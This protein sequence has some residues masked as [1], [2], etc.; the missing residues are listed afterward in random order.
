[1]FC[2]RIHR[3]VT[4]LDAVVNPD[5]VLC[6]RIRERALSCSHP[7][8]SSSRRIAK[9]RTGRLQKSG[10]TRVI[11]PGITGCVT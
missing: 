4:E 11:P 6:Q 1:M 9:Q 3:L 7:A 10:K 2:I 8:W 5:P